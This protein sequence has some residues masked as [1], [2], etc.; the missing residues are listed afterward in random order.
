[1]SCASCRCLRSQ[2]SGSTTGDA[3]ATYAPLARYEPPP[4][5][6]IHRPLSRLFAFTISC[7]HFSAER[8]GAAGDAEGGGEDEG[9]GGGGT[10]DG[11]AAHSDTGAIT[12]PRARR[13]RGAAVRWRWDARSTCRY[14]I[15]LRFLF[16]EVRRRHVAVLC[17]GTRF[18]MMLCPSV[19]TEQI[20]STT[21]HA[22]ARTRDTMYVNINGCTHTDT[23]HNT[24]MTATVAQT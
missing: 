4:P 2:W 14:P 19:I 10:H 7:V 9:R 5:P 8:T 20:E 23:V 1:M 15:L 21:A 3:T 13:R 11:A 24:L 22:T 6:P 12:A 16:Y 18:R 17:A